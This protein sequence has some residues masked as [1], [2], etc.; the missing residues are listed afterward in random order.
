MADVEGEDK[1]EIV[2]VIGGGEQ[3][4]AAVNTRCVSSNENGKYIKAA[5]TAF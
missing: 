5:F 2:N 3:P 4:W 1:I